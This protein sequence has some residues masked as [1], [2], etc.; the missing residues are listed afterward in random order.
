M[1]SIAGSVSAVLITV[2][3]GWL[4][5]APAKE[6]PELASSAKGSAILR[7]T[8]AILGPPPD[9][10]SALATFLNRT[11]FPEVFAAINPSLAPQVEPPPRALARDRE[12][13]LAARLTYKI[14]GVGCGGRVSG[15]GFPVSNN[16]IVTAAHVV[17]GTTSTRVIPAEDV[18]GGPFDARVVYID[19]ETDIAVL[20]VSRLRPGTLDVDQ[21]QAERGT[22]GAAIGYPGGG[23]RKTSVARVRLRTEAIGRNIY[24]RGEVTREIYVLR[25]TVVQ[26]N[27]G[28]PFV[29]TDGVVRG[30]VFA[31][32]ASDP[33]ESYALA[34]TEIL[35]ALRNTGNSNREVNT[36]ACAV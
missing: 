34:E 29:D 32:A 19:S 17:A 18:G 3:M 2:L 21:D 15:S 35:E 16:T 12:V 24:G 26:G 7:G 30:M 23:A 9:L 6:V 22:D 1:D 14:D 28:G 8:H 31:A 36:G 25:A 10:F 27:S 20:R 4:M 33:E 11:G 5:S 13:R